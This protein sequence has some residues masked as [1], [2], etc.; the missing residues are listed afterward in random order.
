MKSNFFV[1]LILLLSITNSCTVNCPDDVKIGEIDLAEQSLEF[2]PYEGK[3]ILFFKNELGEELKFTT[4]GVISEVNRIAIY[5][6]CT[7]FKYDGQSTYEYYEGKTKAVVFFDTDNHYAINYGLF[8]NTLRPEKELFYDKLIVDINAVG[9]IGRGELITAI[10]FSESYDE[11]EFNLDSPVEL[12]TEITLN[13]ITY[14]QV[15]QTESYDGRQAYFTKSQGIVGF[16]H[17]GHTY[18]LDRV[19]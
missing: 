4:E 13:N 15:Y 10:R 1:G 3:P 19:E 14:T 6:I 12:I 8:T 9:S 5:K 16:I 7:E 17:K 2:F 18:N 11:A